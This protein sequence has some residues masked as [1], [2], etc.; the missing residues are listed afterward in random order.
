MEEKKND[1]AAIKNILTVYTPDIEAVNFYL[2]DM[3]NPIGNAFDD[4]EELISYVREN[5]R[6]D[7]TKNLRDFLQWCRNVQRE[8]VTSIDGNKSFADD[9][10]KLTKKLK[11]IIAAIEKDEVQQ[12]TASS[13]Q[14]TEEE[15]IDD[16]SLVEAWQEDLN[17]KFISVELKD[18]YKVY[19]YDGVHWNDSARRQITNDVINKINAKRASIKLEY[20]TCKALNIDSKQKELLL[21]PI[22]ACKNA[23]K[24]Y[25]NLPA[26]KRIVEL[27]SIRNARSRCPF[28][29]NFDLIG[30]KNG[31]VYEISTG[32][33]RPTTPDDMISFIINADWNPDAKCPNYEAALLKFHD[34]H[35][36]EMDFFIDLIGASLKRR[37]HETIRRMVY[38][39]G[40]T[41]KNGKTT[42]MNKIMDILGGYS[43]GL[44]ANYL[45]EARDDLETEPDTIK[46]VN[47]ALAVCDEPS[48]VFRMSETR[49]KNYT[50]GSW[51]LLRTLYSEPIMFQ[52]TALI[53]NMANF[54]PTM[55]GSDGAI[56]E[57][58]IVIPCTYSFAKDNA[59]KELLTHFNDE[60]DGIAQLYIR[61]LRRFIDER[62][63]DFGAPSSWPPR[64]REAT[65]KYILDNDSIQLFLNDWCHEYLKDEEKNKDWTPR[66]H[67]AS[68]DDHYDWYCRNI[69]KQNPIQGKNLRAYMMGKGHE[70]KSLWLNDKTQKCYMNLRWLTK[71]EL[72]PEMQ[73]YEPQMDE[74][75][76]NVGISV[77]KTGK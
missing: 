4:D 29:A 17:K 77:N 40:L 31:Y 13:V 30:F 56:A 55:S 41:G 65:E 34:G 64:I 28:D 73:D 44:K 9:V 72:S 59:A 70:Y 16:T 74:H 18:K 52:F 61:G 12:D 21:K 32:K 15:V 63:G 35:Q 36:D 62:K 19:Y 54:P 39:H 48:K 37:V 71:E 27:Y 22:I 50:G 6:E 76:L 45:S 38:L 7:I 43:T 47:K 57:R 68:F 67:A 10:G 46:T 5:K 58:M 53:V 25:G 2:S 1:I 14:E 69:L 8:L 75:I 11:T 66:V 42:I 60:R 51:F 20:N 33:A 26:I 3:E 24:I 49:S 23:M